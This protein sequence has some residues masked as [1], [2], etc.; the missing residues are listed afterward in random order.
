MK[1]L[2]MRG[3]ENWKQKVVDKLRSSKGING[4]YMWDVL[5]TVKKK[6]EEPTVA[7][8]DKEGKLLED[9]ENIKQR[10]LEYFGRSGEKTGRNC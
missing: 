7:I 9:P 8:K 2:K 5:R 6:K 1:K 3:K 4:L 10:Y